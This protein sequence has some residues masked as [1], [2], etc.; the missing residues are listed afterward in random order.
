M[1]LHRK[2]WL[3]AKLTSLACRTMMRR[4]DFIIGDPAN[5]YLC[6]WFA[7][8]RNPLFNIYVHQI[9][10]SDDDR[11]LHDHPWFSL[12][13]MVGGGYI[14]VMPARPDQPRHLD[15]TPDG[16]RWQPREAGEVV[17][18]SPWARHRLEMLGFQPAITVFITG[19]RLRSWGFHCRNGWVHWKRFTAP[20]N[21]GQIGQGCG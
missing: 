6:R 20:G 9:L 21:R 10:R 19:P 2:G 5:P 11:A 14:E 17:F 7:I 8:P 16:L 12:S 3:F 13:V 15:F 1:R 18:R 4:P